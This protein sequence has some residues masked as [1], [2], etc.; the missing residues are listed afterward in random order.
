MDDAIRKALKKILPTKREEREIH[1]ASE[2]FLVAVEIRAKRYGAEAMLAGSITRN[3]WLRDKKE[4]DIFV[5][6]P[7]NVEKESLEKIGLAIGKS[8]IR[9]LGGHFIL[10]YAQHPYV[11]GFVGKYQVDIVPCYKLESADK[12]KSAVDRTP[13]HVKFIEDNMRPE[14]SKDV[15]LLKQFFKAAGVYG[16]DLKT[17]GFS[18][19]MCD[20]LVIKYGSF[21][22]TVKAI[23]KWAA[24][25]RIT[26]IDTD[27]NAGFEGQPLV[28]VDPVDRKRNAAAAVSAKNFEKLVSYSAKFCKKPSEK[29]FFATTPKPL[30]KAEFVKTSKARGTKMFSIVFKPPKVVADILW[31]QLRRTAER[32]E[33]ILRENDFRVMNT[34]AWSDEKNI[35]MIIVE[36]ETCCLSNVKKKTGPSVFS[37]A[38]SLDFIKHYEKRPV[39][40]PYVERNNWAVEINRKYTYAGDYLKHQIGLGRKILSDKGI[41][42]HVADAIAKGARLS[43][44]ADVYK[45]I[46]SNKDA[47][48]FLREFFGA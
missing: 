13:F 27:A 33:T 24:G 47:K 35:A 30:E 4:I 44:D 17:E 25:M 45:S 43:E 6:L 16:A 3:T 40:G 7:E 8:V 14:Q 32:F 31:P 48:I 26:L 5:A 18:G 38:N 42:G 22:N 20:L 39:R 29:F 41:P 46:N 2:R 15:R 9:S 36:M 34:Q 11:R 19:Y 10:S 23:S 1:T 12:I 28:L 21:Q 37:R